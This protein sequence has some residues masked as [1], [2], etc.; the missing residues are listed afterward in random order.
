MSSDIANALTSATLFASASRTANANSSSVDLKEYD[1]RL[2]VLAEGGDITAGDN[3][4]TYVISLLSSDTDNISN[5]TAA[6]LNV[7]LTNA[8]SQQT[9]GV[10]TRAV[11]RYLFGQGNISGAN[12]PAFPCSVSVIGETKYSS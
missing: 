11:K 12:S 1:G 9:V 3:N 4:S 10:D 8:A 5:A 2:L 6:N 7:T